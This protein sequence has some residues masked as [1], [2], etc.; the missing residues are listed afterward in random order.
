MSG[1]CQVVGIGD[2]STLLEVPGHFELDV[3]EDG[4]V[5]AVPSVEPAVLTLRFSVLTVAAKD[6]SNS[7]N[8]DLAADTIARARK[9]GREVFTAQDK[10]WCCEEKKSEQDGVPLWLRFWQ[11]GYRNKAIIVSLCCAEKY[12][13]DP[14]VKE[15]LG[16]LPK[17]ISTIQQRNTTSS[18][19]EQESAQLDEQRELVSTLLRKSYNTYSLPKINADL[20]VLQQLVDEQPFGVD[21][22]YEWSSVGV[23]FG[24]VI[25]NEVGLNWVAYCDEH[26]V[27]PALNLAETSI[28]VFPRTM[29]LKRVE[30]GERPNLGYILGKLQETV[31][32]MRSKG[33]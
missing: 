15:T 7:K 31:E 19:T 13:T 9:E 21:Q 10:A 16:L 14:L 20:P 6:S 12:R 32:D 25:A 26:G 24:D 33:Y 27:E 1:D 30:K 18:L 8:I 28:T 22:K 5:C 4:T 11:V 23:A 17:L 2:G 29:I 3:E